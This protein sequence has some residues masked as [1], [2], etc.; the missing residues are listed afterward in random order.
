MHKLTAHILGIGFGMTSFQRVL[1]GLSLAL[2][3]PLAASAQGIPFPGS[4]FSNRFLA[5]TLTVNPNGII[6]T[7]G[8]GYYCI[9]FNS[10]NQP[11]ECT[12]LDTFSDFVRFDG[13]NTTW[14]HRQ[15]RLP[16]PGFQFFSAANLNFFSRIQPDMRSLEIIFDLGEP[17]NVLNQFLISP[18]FTVHA[19][20]CDNYRQGLIGRPLD[21]LGQ[22]LDLGKNTLQTIRVQKR[23]GS[24][25]PFPQFYP[26]DPLDDWKTHSDLPADFPYQN[27]DI[28]RLEV[29]LR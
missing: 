16:R 27:F 3:L 14:Y 22:G 1:C 21:T 8:R 13:L 19:L 26:S 25:P 23:Q 4:P 2:G 5:I 6:D 7:S 18:N 9:L 29:N 24:V 15:A 12:D 17:T 11:I 10:F 20:T 28:S